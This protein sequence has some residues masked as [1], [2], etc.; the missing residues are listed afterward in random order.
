[1]IDSALQQCFRCETSV[2]S[3]TSRSSAMIVLE[4]S[5]EA[6]RT[7]SA[8]STIEIA[9]L[10]VFCG[11]GAVEAGEECDEAEQNSDMPNALC[12]TDCRFARCGDGIPDTPLEICDDGNLFN[13]DGCS[14]TCQLERTAPQTLPAQIIDLPFAPTTNNQQPI[15][16]NDQTAIDG[17]YSPVPPANTDTGPAALAV[18]IS[19]A[20]AGIAYMRRKR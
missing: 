6:G 7:S 20:A 2:A 9:D 4:V 5:S 1:M 18:M 13:G 14:A 16:S 10:P 15:T 19:G 11:N 17:Q 3:T 12:R 8:P